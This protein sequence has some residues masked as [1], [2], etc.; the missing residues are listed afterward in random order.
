MSTSKSLR[1]IIFEDDLAMS[2][3][4]SKMLQSFGHKVSTFP[5]PTVCPVYRTPECDCP[6][7]APCADAL[8]TDFM[9]PNM[10]GIELLKLQRI[11]GCKALDVNKAVM[12]ASLIPQHQEAI[13][14]LGCHFF[15]KPF[16]MSEVKQWL[17]GC[18]ERIH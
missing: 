13:K 10:N 6:M 14:E 3:L 17:E 15:K 11:R 18:A 12:S 1:V 16:K 2:A 8:I 9:M 7:E 4:F 5:D